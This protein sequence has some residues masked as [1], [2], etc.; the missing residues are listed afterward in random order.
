VPDSAIQCIA[1]F[2]RIKST[3]GAGGLWA[4]LRATDEKNG[5]SGIQNK[6]LTNKKN[7]KII[8]K[9]TQKYKKLN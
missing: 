2:G 4:R 8:N 9:N 1:S 3:Y 7:I 6:L 5:T